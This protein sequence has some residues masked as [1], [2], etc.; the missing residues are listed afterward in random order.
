MVQVMNFLGIAKN[1][2]SNLVLVLVLVLESIGPL[3]SRTRTTSTRFSHRATFSARKPAIFWRDK[4]GTVVILLRGFARMLS[5]Q[6]K[7]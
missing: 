7:S 5:C 1:G 2:Q 3:D 6:N 4:G